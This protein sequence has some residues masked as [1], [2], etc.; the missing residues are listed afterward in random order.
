MAEAN[1]DRLKTNFQKLLARGRQYFFGQ[2]KQS[3]QWYKNK[4]N[5]VNSSD[6]ILKQNRDLT[7]KTIQGGTGN[8]FLFNYV[9][10]HKNTL[11]VY[12]LYPLCIP[13]KYVPEGFYGVNLHYLDYKT[14]AI[15]FDQ[16]T[17]ILTNKRWDETTRM[18]ISYDWIKSVSRVPAIKNTIKHYLYPYVRSRFMYIP[19]LE[20]ETALFLPLQQFV[21]K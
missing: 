12:D 10:K 20:W 1:L 11:P 18:A 9:P 21:Y 2:Q 7:S 6:S 13:F 15:F 19:P 4:S 14:R 3:I 17:T 5:E 8:M 16:L